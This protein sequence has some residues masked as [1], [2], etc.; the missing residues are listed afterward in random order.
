MTKWSYVNETWECDGWR[1]RRTETENGPYFDVLCIQD[2]TYRVMD[3][4][5]SLSKAQDWIENQIVRGEATT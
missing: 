4:F 1:I 3:R 2:G 5:S